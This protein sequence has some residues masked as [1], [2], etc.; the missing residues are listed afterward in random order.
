MHGIDSGFHSGSP[1]AHKAPYKEMG[2]VTPIYISGGL[3][4]ALLLAGFKTRVSRTL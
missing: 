1:L 4:Q 2:G 3:H